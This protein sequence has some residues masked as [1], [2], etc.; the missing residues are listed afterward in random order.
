MKLRPLTFADETQALQAHSEL[1]ADNFEF[2]LG[3]TE[4][5]EWSEYLQIL[6]KLC[7]GT[8]LPEGRVPATFLIAENDGELVGRTSIRHE[9][10]DFLFTVGGHIGYGVLPNYRRQGFATE[11]LKQS[12]TFINQL[13]ITEVLVTCLEGNVGSKKV[14]QSQ[15][16]ILENK[17]EYEGAFWERYWITRVNKKD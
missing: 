7:A 11:I 13:G 14:I 2:L 17:V 10:N 3:Y 9:L 16:G 1:A 4:G 8:N 6:D 5:M 15:G 12:L